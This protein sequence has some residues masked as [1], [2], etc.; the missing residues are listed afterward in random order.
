[1]N[2]QESS[3]VKVRVRCWATQHL[4]VPH[5]Q[6]SDVRMES[7]AGP[8]KLAVSTMLLNNEYFFDKCIDKQSDFKDCI[9]STIHKREHVF[10]TLVPRKLYVLGLAD[11]DSPPVFSERSQNEGSWVINN[12][13]TSYTIIDTLLKNTTS[14]KLHRIT[15]YFIYIGVYLGF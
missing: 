7:D 2:A 11:R 3:K 14:Y 1:M 10:T 9:R 6:A 5:F 12:L 15:F 13:N 4:P 8:G